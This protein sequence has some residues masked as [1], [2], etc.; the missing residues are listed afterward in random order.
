M[1]VNAISIRNFRRLENISTDIEP[2]ETVFVGPNNSGKTSAASAFRCFLGG[3]DFRVHDFSISRIDDFDS[4]IASG[5]EN[6]LP[7]I[8]LEIWFDIDPNTIEFGRAFTLL[9][10]LLDLTSLGV[11][12]SF[13]IRDAK[14]LR[15]TYSQAYPLKD[16]KRDRTVSQFLALD[17]NLRG[18]SDIKFFSLE[19]NGDQIVAEQLDPEEGKRLIENLVRIDF[20]DAQRNIDDDD[21]SRSN[22]LSSAFASFYRANLKKQEV[23]AD[24]HKVI[25]EN[26]ANLTQHYET[27]FTP[28]I[29]IIRGLGVPSINDRELR[30]VSALS[31]ES[32]LRGS[33]ELLYVDKS[34][35]H[36]LP[37]LYNGLGFKNLIYMAIQAGDYHARWMKTEKNRPLCHIIFIEE[38]E[39]HLHAQVQRTFIHK[40]WEVIQKSAELNNEPKLVPQLIVSTHSSHVLDAVDFGKVRYFQRCAATGD[41]PG[42]PVLNASEV[43]SLRRFQ[44]KVVLVD[45]AEVL[46][47]ESIAF[48]QKYLRLTHCDLFFADGAILVEGAAEKLLLPAMIRR[49][50]PHLESAYVTILEVGGAYSHRFEGLLAFLKIPYVVITDLDSVEPVGHPTTCRADKAGARTSNASLK[51]FFNVTR[52][53]ELLAINLENKIDA[54]KQRCIAFQVEK[55]VVEDGANLRMVARTLEEAIAYENF[56][57][58][59]SGELKLGVDIPATLAAAYDAIYT[60]VKSPDFKKTDFAMELLAYPGNWSVPAYITQSLAWLESR[61]AGVAVSA[62]TIAAAPPAAPDAPVVQ[63]PEGG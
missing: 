52:V 24:A 56:A 17:R 5:D 16:G 19:Q 7:R 43:R 25:D 54:T 18:N 1:R 57:L 4:F 39:V 46:P 20:V 60:R 62:A 23:A 34:R 2:Q 10:K 6:S 50:S 28:L 30:I 61:L 42:H 14:A 12:L 21:S 44:P 63:V 59:R 27:Q 15:E 35:N 36:E 48:L 3:K 51:A 58:F 38:P 47:D 9:P 37:E 49:V 8:E 11:R 40:V 29:S 31:P 13:G 41:P 32:A 55:N 26:N 53:D 22:R 45:E 33:T